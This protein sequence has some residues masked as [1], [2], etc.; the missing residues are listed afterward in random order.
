MSEK[1]SEDFAR[2]AAEAV[3][4]RALEF[5]LAKWRRMA[6]ACESEIERAFVAGWID[7]TNNHFLWAQDEIQMYAKG[8]ADIAC[9]PPFAGLHLW[10]QT[11]IAAYRVDFFIIAAFTYAQTSAP[12]RL[13]QVRV[14]VECD[15]HD[16]HERTKEQ[17]ERDK[18]RDRELT[19]MGLTVL[20]FT[21]REIWRSPVDCA[22]GVLEI[23]ERALDRQIM[24]A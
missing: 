3:S 4:L 13:G 8:C 18:R 6:A 21:G 9:A 7:A 11:T 19:A 23:I 2:E 22:A 14:V 24:A 10:P 16:F 20:R 17:A 1:T 15:G 12:D 5:T